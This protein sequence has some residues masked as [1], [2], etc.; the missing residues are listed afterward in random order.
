MNFITRLCLVNFTIGSTLLIIFGIRGINL[1]ISIGILSVVTASFLI[2]FIK[3]Y[4]NKQEEVDIEKK[5]IIKRLLKGVSLWQF[6]MTAV[7][8]VLYLFIIWR[9]PSLSTLLNFL[10]YLGMYLMFTLYHVI[11]YIIWKRILLSS[12]DE[13]RNKKEVFRPIYK[14]KVLELSI[15]KKFPIEQYQCLKFK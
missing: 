13:V 15:P 6:E 1:L 11:F 14:N 12:I 7:V 3:Y 2:P 10:I 8:W 9:S 5:N 4:K